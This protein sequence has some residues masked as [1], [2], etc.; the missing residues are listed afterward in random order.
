MRIESRRKREEAMPANTAF[1]TEEPVGTGARARAP[2][3]G[4][5]DAAPNLPI[6]Y[7]RAFVTLLV[8]AHHAVLAYHPMAPAASTSLRAEL[9]WWQAFPVVDPERSLGIALFVGWNDV[10]FMSLMFL[11]SGLFVSKSLDRKGARSFLVDRLRRLGLPFVAVATIVAP[12]AYYPSYLATTAPAGIGG[13]AREWL[14]LGTWPAG[15]AWFL[16]LLFAFDAVVAGLFVLRPGWDAALGQRSSALLGRPGRCFGL[17]VAFSAVAYLPLALAF[18]P[19]HWTAFGPFAFQTSRLLHYGVYF[20]VGVVVGAY[21]LER[22]PWAV[23]GRLA[24]SWPVWIGAGLL[25]FAFA[26]LVTL[27]ALAEGAGVGWQAVGGL[28]FV[29]SCAAFSFALLAVFLR[30]ART[31]TRVLESL[32]ANAYGMY[33]VHYAF[34]S[35]LQYAF[36]RVPLSALGKGVVVFL[37]T[38]LLSWSTTAAL[39]RLPAI[40]R[41][42]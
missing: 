27:A 34:V 14:S 41:V 12:L 11:L 19:L 8:L 3:P 6:G 16:W 22:G 42:L 39:R 36:L 15:P 40:R 13:Y 25:A 21:G 17:L 24:R 28:G 4:V 33:L 2:E 7:L 35:W 37:G 29:V 1:A 5:V 31:R 26:T 23:G 32:R 18:S 20:L 30:F 9:R 38:V 10:F